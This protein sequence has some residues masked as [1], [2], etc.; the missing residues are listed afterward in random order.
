MRLR[1]QQHNR[2]RLLTSTSMCKAEMFFPKPYFGLLAPTRHHCSYEQVLLVYFMERI[3]RVNF[4]LLLG[5]F[6]SRAALLDF[7]PNKFCSK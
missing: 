6:T 5:W 2:K 3:S 1:R 4:G 7:F